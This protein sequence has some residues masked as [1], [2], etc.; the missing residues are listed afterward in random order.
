MKVCDVTYIQAFALDVPCLQLHTRVIATATT[1]PD[2]L[3]EFDPEGERPMS[4]EE[5]TALVAPGR[6]M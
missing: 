6:R 5:F 1:A 2:L 4:F 3:A